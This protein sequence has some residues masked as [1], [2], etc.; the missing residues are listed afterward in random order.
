MDNQINDIKPAEEA[1][2]KVF[3]VEFTEEQISHIKKFGN[4][5]RTY[6]VPTILI[7]E[8]QNFSRSLLEGM[9]SRSN[10]CYTAANVQQAIALYAEHIPS[11]VFLDI[12][13]PDAVG[14]EFAALLKKHDPNNFVVM[15]TANNYT[16]DVALAQENNA[17]GFIVKPY[18]RQKII[19]AIDKY[20]ERK[21]KK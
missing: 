20:L 9:L 1:V 21:L 13:L 12:E 16:K 3:K 8:D 6:P 7:V 5:R 10:P 15:V 11:I 4:E 2:D 17:Q 19:T 14:H 18:S